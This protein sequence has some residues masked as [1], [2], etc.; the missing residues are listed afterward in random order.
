MD[1]ELAAIVLGVILLLYPAF[2]A[3]YE[4][5]GGND[6]MYEKKWSH[7]VFGSSPENRT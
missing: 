4:K 1:L 6:V 2:F 3:I 7:R 5:I